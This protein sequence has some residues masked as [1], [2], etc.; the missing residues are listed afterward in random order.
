MLPK[1]CRRWFRKEDK[2][3]GK[4][5]NGNSYYES[6]EGKRWVKYSKIFEPTTVSPEWHIW[7]HYTDDTVPA[8]STK[9]THNLTGT[10]HAYYPNQKV[11]DYYESWNPNNEK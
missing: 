6:N 4:D 5:E 2:F 10:E 11:K 3:V 1:V 9:H 8:N 7:L